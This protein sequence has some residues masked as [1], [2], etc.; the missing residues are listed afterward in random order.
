MQKILALWATPRSTS[1]A[2][3]TVMKNRGDMTC[4]HEPYNEAFYCGVEYRHGRY[5]EADP[6]LKPT[7]G[8][9]I[10]SVHDKLTTLAEGDSVFVKDFAY[11]ISHMA[12]DR[13]LDAF[14]HSFLIRDP[15]KVITSMHSRWPDVS[16][17][18]IG[19]DDLH[20]LFNRVADRTGKAPFVIDSDALLASPVAGMSA[21]CDAVGIPFISDSM[22]WEKQKE[23][24]EKENP[25][26]NTDEH[27]FHDSLKAST[28]L[29]QQ[30]RDYP[31]LSS[32]ADML[33]LYDA[34]LPLYLALRE[35]CVNIDQSVNSESAT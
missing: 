32:S 10:R 22:N 25:T 19:F 20:T 9:S 1:T 29:K 21:Y 15:E 12:D 23:Q 13:F 6:D 11:S 5:F 17:A 24:H 33:R 3:E 34:C 16:L 26:W 7:P 27:G 30:K 2:F 14:T 35:F 8:L 4:F 18:E 28:G 31:P